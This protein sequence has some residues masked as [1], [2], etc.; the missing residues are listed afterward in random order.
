MTPEQTS[1]VTDIIN[2]MKDMPG[3][4]LPILHEIQTH[5]RYVPK[6]SIPDI[7][8]AL[9]LSQ[10]EVHGVMTFYHEFRDHPPGKHV[11]KIC[12]AESCQ[13]M[14]SE[15]IEAKAK[16]ILEVD[17]HGTSSNGEITLEPVYCLGMCACSP[18]VMINDELHARVTP[19]QLTDLLTQC[20]E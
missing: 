7:A 1:L 15:Q 2:R 12:R 6:Q 20:Q 18:A 10:A 16:A 19:E 9:N 13:S 4:L 5:L 14:G 17:Y 3:A 11:V 8:H